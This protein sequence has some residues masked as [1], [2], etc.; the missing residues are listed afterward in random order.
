MPTPRGIKS[1]DDQHACIRLHIMLTT[2]AY[3]C[4]GAAHQ[5]G[6]VA[7]LNAQQPSATAKHQVLCAGDFAVQ[8]EA[9]A[10]RLSKGWRRFQ[11]GIIWLCCG[12]Q[13]HALPAYITWF[14]LQSRS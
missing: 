12:N 8:A 14:N 1:S 5:K 4:N 9:E 7:S 13:V 6:Y 11:A 10:E 2:V 3:C